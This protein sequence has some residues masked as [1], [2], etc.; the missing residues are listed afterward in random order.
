MIHYHGTPVGGKLEERAR[1]LKGRHALVSIAYPDDI[2]LVADTCQSFILD[3]GAFTAWKSGTSTDWR[4]YYTW[5]ATW[6]GHPGFDFAIIPDVI[7][8]DEKD[9]DRLLAEWPSDLNGVPVW[10][11][12]ESIRR[13]YSLSQRYE[14][15]AIGSSGEWSSPGSNHWWERMSAVMDDVCTAG[16]PPCQLHGLRMLNPKVFSRLPLT[17]ADSVNASVNAGSLK[18]FGLY[19]PPSRSQRASVIADRIETFNSA[20]V[21]TGAGSGCEYDFD[22]FDQE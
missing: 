7:D 16:V 6:A 22:E 10:H 5:V 13:L 21:W 15:V 14:K 18:R 2:A 9:N 12:H 4:R 20:P 19:I 1:F 8:G 3:N 17:S 11:L